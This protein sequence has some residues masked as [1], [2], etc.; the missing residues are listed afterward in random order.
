VRSQT[1]L[2]SAPKTCFSASKALAYRFIIFRQCTC[3]VNMYL[4]L[5]WLDPIM[6][7]YFLKVKKISL[8]N[9]ILDWLVNL[10]YVASLRCALQG[11]FIVIAIKSYFYRQCTYIVFIQVPAM[12][13]SPKQ[14][15]NFIDESRNKC[16]SNH[17]I[18]SSA[19]LLSF[20]TICSKWIRHQ[21]IVICILDE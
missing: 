5:K 17:F 14:L 2:K 18:V 11:R 1:A 9:I 13:K 12:S 15:P 8:E 19:I 4:H 6:L 3:F 16:S 7:S 10:K 21:E 20:L